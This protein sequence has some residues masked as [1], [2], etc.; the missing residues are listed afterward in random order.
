MK[1]SPTPWK[2]ETD[3]IYDA[4]GKLVRDSD[5][6]EKRIVACVNFC[7][8][9]TTEALEAAFRVIEIDVREG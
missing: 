8:N 9:W 4:D 6:N 5:E 7:E 1:H 3:G 2:R